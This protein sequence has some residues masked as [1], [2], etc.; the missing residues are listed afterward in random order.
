MRFAKILRTSSLHLPR[1]RFLVCLSVLVLV[2][3][4]FS[5]EKGKR[6]KMNLFSISINIEIRKKGNTYCLEELG[7]AQALVFVLENKRKLDINSA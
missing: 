5:I 2:C 3:F 7:L 4:F 1:V 6:K